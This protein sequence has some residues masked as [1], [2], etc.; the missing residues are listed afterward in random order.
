MREAG[1]RCRV[2]CQGGRVQLVAPNSQWRDAHQGAVGFA[3]HVEALGAG[4]PGSRAGARGAQVV[5]AW[6][7]GRRQAAEAASGVA[8]S[9]AT[10][11]PCC[12]DTRRITLRG[13]VTPQTPLLLVYMAHHTAGA[14]ACLPGLTSMRVARHGALALLASPLLF[15]HLPLSASATE[16]AVWQVMPPPK[17]PAA[18]Q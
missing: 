4:L 14:C 7:G 11:I 12:W 17:A 9:I 3:V 8:K 16:N 6:V 10:T 13:N 15:I 1:V 18:C 2:L 5:Q